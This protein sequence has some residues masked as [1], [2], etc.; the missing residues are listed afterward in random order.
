MAVSSV[1][2]AQG[3]QR[4]EL[5]YLDDG[6]T[7]GDEVM[8]AR[9]TLDMVRQV[10]GHL[11]NLHAEG[12][13]LASVINTKT[14]HDS[15]HRVYLAK[16]ELFEWAGLKK[17]N[18]SDLL[19]NKAG[20]REKFYRQ[21]P[22]KPAELAAFYKRILNQSER[23]GYPF[24]QVGLDSVQIENNKIRAAIDYQP[25]PLIT[26]DSLVV[27]PD[28]SVKKA[29]LQTYL[30]I[31]P[32][33]PF[34]QAVVDQLDE[35]I[36]DLNFL[37]MDSL[38]GITF[39]N[40]QATVYLHV[41]KVPV[42]TI[43]GIVGFLPNEKA[44]GSM[45]ITGEFDMSL[46][47]LF[48]SGK[49]LGVH[50]Q[51][52]K[53]ES[54]LLE[55]AYRHPNLLHSPL[56]FESSFYLLKED[57]TFLN[58]K[59]VF[60][61]RY[62]PGAHGLGFFTRLES[63]RLLGTTET[64]LTTNAAI[65]DFN[66]NYYG[67]N[68]SYK[69]MSRRGVPRGIQSFIELAIGDKEVKQNNLLPPDAFDRLARKSTQY[70]MQGRLQWLSPVGKKLGLSTTIEGGKLINDNLFLNDLFRVGGLNSLRG[71]N[72]NFFFAS[73][74]GLLSMELR[75]YYSY[76]SFLFIFYDQSY[77]YYNLGENIFED[78]PLGVGAGLS[79]S[80]GKG[81]L[82]LVYALGRSAEQP[83]SIN[84]SKFHFGYTAKF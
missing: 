83:M 82:N 78:Y 3:Q 25:G 34:N 38:P 77:L 63:S 84:L 60:R 32:G 35:K 75:Y 16:G 72:E 17:G 57:T 18:L 19:I 45:L 65:S 53:P 1:I 13:L 43:D 49:G 73:D 8:T 29:W 81:Q 30:Q 52:L 37:S 23:N 31:V 80:V 48:N 14:V 9:D 15:L 79:L 54:Q 47:N 36:D 58:R 64:A 20:F 74:Y 56:H 7:S 39:Q 46:Y 69:K 33:Q 2:F 6:T 68:Y 12:Y 67:L 22:F 70:F 59:G 28:V 21:R 51:S 10:N 41:K 66:V 5:I 62:A 24:A 42:N 4:V 27:R 40:E 44:D 76:D 26:F 50:W 71:F 11:T 61:L 55:I